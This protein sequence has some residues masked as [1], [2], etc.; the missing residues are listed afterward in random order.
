MTNENSATAIFDRINVSGGFTSTGATA[1]GGGSVVGS[2]GLVAAVTA[3][4]FERLARSCPAPVILRVSDRNPAGSDR[5]RPHPAA[6]LTTYVLPWNGIVFIATSAQKI[7]FGSA[8][9]EI[10]CV[11]VLSDGRPLGRS[12]LSFTEQGTTA[13]SP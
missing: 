1:G 7:E 5:K 13:T 8:A 9:R 6:Q 11:A 4:E 2:T 12:E 10:P 3:E